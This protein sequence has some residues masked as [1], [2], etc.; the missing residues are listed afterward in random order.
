MSY[1][2][3]IHRV[4]CEDFLSKFQHFRCKH[5]TI[6]YF[7]SYNLCNLFRKDMTYELDT[8]QLERISH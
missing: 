4:K 6:S 1:S 3:A 7:F 5:V 2:R 8:E